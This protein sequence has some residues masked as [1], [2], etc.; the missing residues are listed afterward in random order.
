MGEMAFICFSRPGYHSF[1]TLF[2]LYGFAFAENNKQKAVFKIPDAQNE[3]KKKCPNLIWELI[4]IPGKKVLITIVI[5]TATSFLPDV[6]LGSV[7]LTLMSSPAPILVSSLSRIWAAVQV[8]V[9]REVLSGKSLCRWWLAPS[10][11]GTVNS[12]W[13]KLFFSFFL[14][15]S[16]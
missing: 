13:A 1:G 12:T 10:P 7:L 4:K 9:L 11:W 16:P 2:L 8:G 3:K 6:E 15:S 14:S 5:I